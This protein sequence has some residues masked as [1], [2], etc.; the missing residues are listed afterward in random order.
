MQ[1]YLKQNNT[2][3]SSPETRASPNKALCILIPAN[4]NVAKYTFHAIVEK[5]RKIHSSPK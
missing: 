4:S 3:P 1:N 5:W 2:Q